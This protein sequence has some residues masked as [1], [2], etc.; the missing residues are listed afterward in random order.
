MLIS[1]TEM[2]RIY[3]YR[4]F[5]QLIKP[6]IN[7]E[8][9][10]RIRGATII[11]LC[12]N[13]S[14]LLSTLIYPYM[15][16]VSATIRKQLNVPLFKVRNESPNEK[17]YDSGNITPGS[18]EYPVFYNTFT[19]FIK[20]GHKIGKVEPLFKMIAEADVKALKERFGGK[21]DET[22]KKDE[23]TA[24]K[25]VK[26]K[27]EK[28]EEKSSKMK[29]AKPKENKKPVETATSLPA[30][31]PFSDLQVKSLQAAE[32]IALLKKQIDQIKLETTPEFQANKAKRLQKENEQLR[33]KI[34]L[35]SSELEGVD[36]GRQA[37][38]TVTQAAPV[39]KNEKTKEKKPEA[40]PKSKFF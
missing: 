32:L 30:S 34:E 22:A 33:K 13:L 35:L 39:V 40:A 29:E 9:F 3:L 6:T 23:S 8:Y 12:V 27:D 18:Y 2:I 20:E 21:Q 36:A 1:L 5:K 31:T 15:P 25:E 7:N 17:D 26:K 19:N 28:K 16:N 14:Y 11:S 4:K 37:S 38:T 10:V 24:K